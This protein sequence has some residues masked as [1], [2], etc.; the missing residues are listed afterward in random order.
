MSTTATPNER[1]TPATAIDFAA[2]LVAV[3]AGASTLIGVTYNVAFFFGERQNWLFVLTV[4]DNVTATLY[5]LP[6]VVGVLLMMGWSAFVQRVFDSAPPRRPIFPTRP[7]AHWAVKIT[8]H[9]A[10]VSITVALSIHV[11][12]LRGLAYAIVGG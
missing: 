10:I 1:V 6:Y 4:G 12:G 2:K 7:W 8:S 3:I 9:A 5:A 11:A